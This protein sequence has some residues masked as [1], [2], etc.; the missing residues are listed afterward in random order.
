LLIIGARVATDL[1]LKTLVR[2]NGQIKVKISYN[3]PKYIKER[4][5]LARELVQNNAVVETLAQ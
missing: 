3:D 4:H 2:E 1:P 5:G